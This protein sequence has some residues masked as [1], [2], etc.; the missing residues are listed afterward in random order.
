MTDILTFTIIVF[1]ILAPMML[2][3][4]TC[5]RQG[6]GLFGFLY[7]AEIGVIWLVQT[8]LVSIWALLIFNVGLTGWIFFSK[9]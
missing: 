2:V 1:Y 6:A 9:R 3:G 8:N 5:A 7:G 4:L